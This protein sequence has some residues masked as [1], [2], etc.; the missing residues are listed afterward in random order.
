MLIG[1]A[2]QFDQAGINLSIVVTAT[3]LEMYAAPLSAYTEVLTLLRGSQR[4]ITPIFSNVRL[5]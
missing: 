1:L 5:R 3:L 4:T 2:G